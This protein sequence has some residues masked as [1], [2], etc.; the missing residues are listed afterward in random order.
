MANAPK[1][2]PWRSL[3]FLLVITVGLCVWA[4]WPGQS[5]TPRLGLDLQGGTQ[6]TLVPKSVN[7]GGDVT[8][9][10]LE[11]S[12]EIIRQ[13][14]NGLGVSEAEV[15]TQG[16]GGSSAII[17]SVPGENRQGLEQQLSQTAL[18][19]FRPVVLEESSAPTPA[20][21][22]SVVP[23]PAPTTTKKAK[24]G[25]SA[26]MAPTPTPSPSA[27]TPDPTKM[28]PPI[29]APTNSE[30][31]QRAYAALDCSKPENYQGGTPDK[32][33]EWLVTCSKDGSAKYLLEPAFIRG[34]QVSDAQAQLP[35]NGAGGWQVN[36]TFDTEG[37]KALADVSTRLVPL[38]PPKNQFG[39][40]LDG[41]VV[42]SPYFQEPILGGTA[43]INGNF[44]NQQAKD[45]ANVLKYGALPVN[46][47]IAEI[48]SV[49]PT[50]GADQLKAGLIAGALGLLLVVI[51]LLLYY[52]ALGI[53]AVVSLMEAALLTYTVFVILGRTVGLALTLAGVAGAI[54]SIGIT[55]DSFVVYFERIRDDVRE[56]KS[57]RVACETGW[58]KARNTLLAADF[59]SFLAA[60]ILYFISIGNVRGFAF[61]LGLTTIVD[62]VVA[63]L[64]TRPIVALLARSK[65]FTR[66]G[67]LTG[68]S[69]E[70]LGVEPSRELVEARA[71]KARRKQEKQTV[72]AG[73]G[74]GASSEGEGE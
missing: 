11:Q 53:V 61:T 55:A 13:R 68:V 16:S 46:L 45:L 59:V 8:A 40:I 27:A 57:L 66:G 35:Q 22:P 12:V 69:P 30:F 52:R 73:V 9:E 62:V 72:S 26:R 21:E 1:V 54:V 18:L 41:L 42:S 2:R 56:R 51:Y 33:E 63:F 65:W 39:I 44:T 70:R 48:T 71:E 58:S 50:L 3:I 25:S 4:F 37:A 31:L 17:V 36:L 6:V 24:K 60:A 15:T 23:T 10:Q 47:Q 34:T 32:P 74:N 19:D 64:F 5:H 29:Q 43:S 49:S 7:G 14:V 28:R 20:P 38:Q 67:P